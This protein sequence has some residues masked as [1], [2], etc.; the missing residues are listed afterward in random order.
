VYLVLLG[1]HTRVVASLC[2]ACPQGPTGCCT[3]PPDLSWTDIG[4]V[5]SLGGAG[6]LAEQVQR[7][8]LLRGPRGL[9]VQRIPM[10]AGAPTKCVYH[11]EQGCTE[12][13]ERRSA[14]CNYYV[15]S[16]ALAEAGPEAT[17][18]EAGSAAWTAAYQIWDEILSAEVGGWESQGAGPADEARLFE[19]LG[20]RFGE[21]SGERRG[22]PD[23]AR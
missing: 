1:P 17:P 8:R 13:P 4:R 7:G 20:R 18:V 10:D 6:W 22:E 12:P 2:A 9:V 14:A 11:G 3:S 5:A 16:E 15:C 19:H 23:P 21:L